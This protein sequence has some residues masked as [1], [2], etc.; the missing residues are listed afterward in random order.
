MTENDI[1]VG[2]KKCE[3]LSLNFLSQH[4]VGVAGTA[5]SNTQLVM[6]L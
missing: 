5:G 6:V 1:L 2:E 3:G 4:L